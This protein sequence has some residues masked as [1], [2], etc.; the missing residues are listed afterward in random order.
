[1]T[2]RGFITRL[3]VVAVS[4]FL[5]ACAGAQED[6]AQTPDVLLLQRYL[7]GTFD[8]VGEGPATRMIIETIAHPKNAPKDGPWMLLSLKPSPKLGWMQAFYRLTQTSAGES[9]IESWRIWPDTVYTPG[10]DRFTLA[11]AARFTLADAARFDMSQARH[12]Q[13]CDVLLTRNT[14]GRFEGATSPRGACR[15][16]RQGADYI[17]AEKWYEANAFML[18]ENGYDDA[19]NYVWGVRDQGIVFRRVE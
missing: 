5:A 18:R 10:G 4:V 14:A 17:W 12:T 11:D 9:V 13:G 15:N 8:S 1:M 7:D 16:T 3:V 2:G 6:M 19:D